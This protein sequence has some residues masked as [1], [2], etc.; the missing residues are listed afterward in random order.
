MLYTTKKH[1][2]RELWSEVH[3]EMAHY[4]RAL[5]VA[6][7]LQTDMTE[8]PSTKWPSLPCTYVALGL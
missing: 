1:A 2:S 5:C 3:T 8:M 4:L 6:L 7:G